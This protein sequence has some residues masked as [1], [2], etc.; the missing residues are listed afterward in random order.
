MTLQ[1]IESTI[2][3]S[4]SVVHS[5]PQRMRFRFPNMVLIMRIILSSPCVYQKMAHTLNKP[6]VV[7]KLPEKFPSDNKPSLVLLRLRSGCKQMYELFVTYQTHDHHPPIVPSLISPRLTETSIILQISI[8]I[9]TLHY[10]IIYKTHDKNLL[11]II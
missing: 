1:E 8:L 6:E 10:H 3:V 5:G 4:V 11:L 9:K 7:G 2:L